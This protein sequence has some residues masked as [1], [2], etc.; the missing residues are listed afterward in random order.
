[1]VG[2]A[3][4]A[5]ALSA[6]LAEKGIFVPAIRPPTVPEATSRVRI[7]VMATHTPEDLQRALD[8]FRQAGK[9]LGFLSSMG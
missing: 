5:L 7:T 2:E 4:R 3:Q 9:R 6:A 1:M 8:A